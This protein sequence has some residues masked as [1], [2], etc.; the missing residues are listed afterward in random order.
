M[1]SQLDVRSR[2]STG[3]RSDRLPKVVLE[4]GP[5]SLFCAMPSMLVGRAIPEIVDVPGIRS[6]SNQFRDSL[7][8]REFAYRLTQPVVH[9]R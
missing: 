1:Y 3:F 7:S 6:A 8:A 2:P 5:I 9:G 4:V